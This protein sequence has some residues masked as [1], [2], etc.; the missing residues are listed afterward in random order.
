M[1]L[2]RAEY[3]DSIQSLLPDNSTQ[4]ISPLDLRTSLVNLVDSVPNFFAGSTVDAANFASPST[5]T[6][7][8]GNLA[9]SNIGLT[10][11][12]SVDN[13]AFGYA[14]L[15][16]NY[17]GWYNTAV[18]SYALGCNLY[19]SGNTAVGHQALV[20][21]VV[22]SGNVGIGNYTLNNNRRGNYN[23]AIGHGAGWYE[24]PEDDF[25]FH[26]GS[27]PVSSGDFCEGDQPFYSGGAPL[28]YGNLLPGSHQLAIGTNT[29]HDFGMLQVSGDI[30][31][32][33]SGEFNLGRSQHPWNSVNETVYFSGGNV[34]VG[35][36]PSGDVHGLVDS[37]LT[38]HGDLVP[39]LSKRYALG[40]PELLWDGYFN[41]V[42][43]S[44]N[45]SVNDIEYNT[46]TQC[47]Y[48]CK[49][50]HLATSGFCDPSEDGFHNDAVCGYLNDQGL[51]G[52]GL[53]VH[54][55]GSTYRRDY[56]FVYR[57]PD[58]NLNC[59][60]AIDSYTRSRW[61]S[62]ISL[63]LIDNA[64]FI[65]DRLLG[66]Y[67]TGM[68]IESGCMGV[69]LEPYEASGQRLVVGQEPHFANQY[70]TLG[71][72]NFISRSGTD[73]V[74]GNPV[75]YDY[76]SLYGTVDSGVKVTQEFASR[77]RS[78]STKRG[79]SLVYHDEMDQE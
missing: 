2:T 29:L 31:P 3:L 57:Y 61:E 63:E 32:T 21:N 27:L 73:I 44:G 47:L 52:A 15:R 55:S 51:D 71:D 58:P 54:S 11:R 79:F 36:M 13:S 34:G 4:E 33:I 16:N 35:G 74:D 28:L 26:L 66:R 6:T 18:G 37:A 78:S 43:V 8:G 49:T 60:S 45:I 24:G 12:S 9:L 56:R 25:K 62:N 14:S 77:I 30:S 65:G 50:L 39:N 7:L 20:G 64:A 19:G 69:F 41:D 22:G 68:A 38:V 48:E 75:G 17:H 53:E 59:L 40:H 1:I 46:I 70:P 76:T 67:D 72:V 42:I 5:R 10:G 23:I